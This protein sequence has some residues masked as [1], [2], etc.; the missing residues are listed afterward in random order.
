MG[1][2]LPAESDD[3]RTTAHKL[4]RFG[5]AAS[6]ALVLLLL[7]GTADL[8]VNY[9][10]AAR[11]VDHTAEVIGEIR[12]TRGL[13]SGSQELSGT[14]LQM[15]IRS[16]Q[17]Q[18]DHVARLVADNPRQQADLAQFRSMFPAGSANRTT[19]SAE[20]IAAAN[21]ILDRMQR[22]EDRLLVSRVAV[23]SSLTRY[24]AA[25]AGGLCAL[26]LALGIV[27]GC[28][29]RRELRRRARAEA[30][31][32]RDKEE[33]TRYTEELARVSAGSKL[34]QAARDEE[35]LHKIV[36]QVM[37]E[38]I[39]GS[40]GYFALVGAATETVEICGVWG[41][42]AAPAA[43]LPADCMALQLGTP[44][45]R[46]NPVIP[47]DCAHAR[48]KHGDHLC[49]PVHS[50][51]GHM[52]VLHVATSDKLSEKRI[53]VISVFA[54]H[55]GLGLTNLRMREALRQQSV[56][57]SLTGVYNRRHFDEMLRREMSAAARHSV[58]LAVL[59]L[60]VDHFKRLN[61]T[62]GHAAGDDALL[63]VARLLTHC[64]RESDVICRY[65]GE[66]FGVILPGSTLEQAYARAEFCRGIV[67][68]AQLQSA[69]RNLGSITVSI[70][71][72]ISTEFTDPQEI[73]R[74]ADAALYQAKRMGRN[75]TWA[76]TNEQ[77]PF[78]RV[79]SSAVRQPW[80]SHD[81]SPSLPIALA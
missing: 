74:A 27:T 33:L 75:S 50:A 3:V 47:I 31:L 36:E 23:Q 32:V 56:R 8:I 52:G 78:P 14:A 61:D 63:G 20:D 4:F 28:A 34:I 22:Q 48:E 21:A 15:K 16:I 17:E 1:Y 80:H 65:G 29:L 49:L 67:E 81:E 53:H 40:R 13:L 5:A 71:V 6:A 69:G 44:T 30:E 45:H 64:F 57:D 9:M 79:P 39:P 77:M 7:A 24:A 2:A 19:L 60:D 37:R 66:E 55:I 42:D 73:V 10:R 25:A 59:M 12:G 18:F 68:S 76:C 26:L 38:L 41:Y 11:W 46:R 43:F 54:A 51:N 58:P 70:G 35:Q 62:Q 72:A